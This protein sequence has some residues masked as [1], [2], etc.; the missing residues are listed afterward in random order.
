MPQIY[1]G[2]RRK[3]LQGFGGA[4]EGGRNGQASSISQSVPQGGSKDW[5]E[6]QLDNIVAWSNQF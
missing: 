2:G 5:K 3:Q 1:M 6:G 4:T